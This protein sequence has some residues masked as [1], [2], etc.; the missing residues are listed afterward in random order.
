MKRRKALKNI[1]LSLSTVTMSPAVFGILQSCAKEESWQPVFFTLEEADIVSKTLEVMLP[2]TADIP[3]AMDLNQAQFIDGYLLAIPAEEEQAAFK[4]GIE[5][6]LATTLEVTGKTTAKK[7]KLQD[8]EERLAYYLKA[9]SA[10]QKNWDEEVTNKSADQLPSVD[11]VNFSVLKSLRSRGI[12]AFKMTEHI[13][14]NVLAYRSI[15]GQ[16][17]GCVDLQETTGGMA[18]SL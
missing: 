6:Y 9:D 2:T 1:G 13:G 4:A 14:E 16:Q 7:L 3:G 12:S 18:W 17:K 5:Q 10:Q 11:A 15:P 8:I